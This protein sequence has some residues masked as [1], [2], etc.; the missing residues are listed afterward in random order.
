MASKYNF[1]LKASQDLDEAFTYITVKLCNE[2]AAKKLFDKVNKTISDISEFP[3]MCP[4]IDN[5]LISRKD[6]RKAIVDNYILYYVYDESQKLVTFVR[7]VYGKR[8]QND[9]IKTI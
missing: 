3:K 6:V 7:F 1:T 4:V 8:D 9:I 2:D 5:K